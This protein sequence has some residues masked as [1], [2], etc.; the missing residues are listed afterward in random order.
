MAAI[1]FAIS[2]D[3]GGQQAERMDDVRADLLAT[4][5]IQHVASAEQVIYNMTQWG[6]DYSDLKFD[7][8]GTTDYDTDV[9][10]QVYH[11]QGGGLQVPEYGDDIFEGGGT[12][13]WQW[14]N[15]NNVEW[16]PTLATDLIFSFIDLTEPVCESINKQLYGNSMIPAYSVAFDTRFQHDNAVIQDINVSGCPSCDSNKSFCV[17]HPLGTR[18]LFYTII[19]SR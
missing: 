17:V 10:N 5:L 16:S 15:L 19:G 6:A 3:G 1:T 9:T 7:L 14:Q 4:Q 2:R 18:F 8:P 13:G 12:R 11:P